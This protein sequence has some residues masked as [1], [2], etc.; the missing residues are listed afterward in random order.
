MKG[1][2]GCL[3]FKPYLA[4]EA[5]CG[6]LWPPATGYVCRPIYSLAHAHLVVDLKPYQAVN[7]SSCVYFCSTLQTMGWVLLLSS[8][9]VLS[10]WTTADFGKVSPIPRGYNCLSLSNYDRAKKGIF[11][12]SA[13]WLTY[14]DVHQVFELTGFPPSLQEL[15]VDREIVVNL[16]ELCNLRLLYVRITSPYNACI[17]TSS[18]TP[19]N[20]HL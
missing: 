19:P 7:V 20:N 12:P 18:Y 16:R 10:V 1:A 15:E 4:S 8:L 2:Q 14:G 13:L 9:P 5:M 17:C 6:N 3:F 11:E